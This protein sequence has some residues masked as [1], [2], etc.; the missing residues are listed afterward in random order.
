MKLLG[1]MFKPFSRNVSESYANG[2]YSRVNDALPDFM[3]IATKG[4]EHLIAVFPRVYPAIDNVVDLK[5][6]GI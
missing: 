4:L 3:T 1:V 6:F 2:R 5:L